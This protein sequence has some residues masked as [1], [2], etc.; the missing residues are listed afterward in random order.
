[1]KNP[2]RATVSSVEELPNVGKAIAANLLL[3]GIK[4]PQDLIGRDPLQLYQ[5]ICRITG[6]RQDPCLLDVFMSLT[7]FMDGGEPLPWWSFTAE[8]K[9]RAQ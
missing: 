5:Q 9:K 4:H 2:D 8:R 6:K 3:L 1:V 7:H